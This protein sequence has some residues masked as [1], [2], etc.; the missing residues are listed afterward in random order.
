MGC[1]RF[2]PWSGRGAEGLKP[3]QPSGSWEASF[4]IGSTALPTQPIEVS[5]GLAKYAWLS[6]GKAPRRHER[7]HDSHEDSRVGAHPSQNVE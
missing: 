4:V 5:I 6:L 3:G 2:A 7:H 1:S